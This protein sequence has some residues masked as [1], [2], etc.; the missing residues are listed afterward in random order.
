MYLDVIKCNQNNNCIFVNNKCKNI[1]NL[2]DT[3][4][5]NPNKIN[6]YYL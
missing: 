3:F 5:T 6:E 4:P 1:D 2:T